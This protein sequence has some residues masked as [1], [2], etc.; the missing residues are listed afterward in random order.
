MR[1]R[2]LI[3]DDE[4]LSR[5]RLRQFLHAEEHTEIVAECGTGTETLDAITTTSPDLVFLD[6]R[7]PELD[8]FAVLERLGDNRP[9]A[10]IFVTAHHEFA[11]RAFEIAAIDY[12]LKPFDRD[13]FRV[14]FSRARTR[15]ER[16]ATGPASETTFLAGR[17]K[18][19]ERVAVRLQGRIFFV[20]TK[21]IDWLNAADN[22]VQLHVGKASHF[23]RSTLTSL[24]TQLPPNQ[25]LRI[26]RSHLVNVDRIKEI[27][28]KTHGD[29]IV[30]LRRHNSHWQSEVPAGHISRVEHSPLDWPLGR[31]LSG[32]SLLR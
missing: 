20:S 1:L 21:D 6:V 8:G 28:S 27:R 17:H 7:M 5:E 2:V 23:L 10:I 24:I 4:P 13:R 3:A 19:T 31:S 18:S 15:L 29:F 25:F 30:H 12:L 26:N 11:V 22:Y 14:A 32:H 16:G 9:P